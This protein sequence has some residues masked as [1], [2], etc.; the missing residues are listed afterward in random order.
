MSNNEKDTFSNHEA[1]NEGQ[2]ESLRQEQQE[3]L[4]D[5]LERNVENRSQ[6]NIETARREALEKAGTAEKEQKTAEKDSSK[7]ERRG[8]LSKKEKD[9]SFDTTMI[10]I[11]THMSAPGRVFSGFIHNKAVEKVSEAVGSTIA[12]PNAI[13][14]GAIFAF[15]FT[16]VIYL[17]ARHNGYPISGSETIASFALGW[18]VGLL[19]DYIRVLVL[20]KNK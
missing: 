12:R 11:R 1:F 3:R 7:Q 18:I 17:V 4:K 15:V 9:V 6:D 5:D 8:P 14:S 19:F 16:L 2:L 10:E 13:L 20:G